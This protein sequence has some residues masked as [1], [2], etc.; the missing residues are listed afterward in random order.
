MLLA[1]IIELFFLIFISL[2]V[3]SQGNSSNKDFIEYKFPTQVDSI[4]TVKL[5]S[6]N[7]EII[8]E[9]IVIDFNF[10]CID[11]HTNYDEVFSLI[12][13]ENYRNDTVHF[14]HYLAKN[15]NRYYVSSNRK[16][17][18]P[19][20]LSDADKAFKANSIKYPF[21]LSDSPRYIFLKLEVKWLEVISI[22]VNK[23]IPSD[24]LRKN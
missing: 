1:K 3:F 23:K 4:I 21:A 2:S 22:D 15:S 17:K 18:I 9:N 14:Y 12:Y 8:K 7:I 16:Y 6:L 10:N 5:D 20:V 19:I 24:M 13:L 11:S